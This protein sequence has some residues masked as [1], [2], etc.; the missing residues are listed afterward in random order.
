MGNKKQKHIPAPPTREQKFLMDLQVQLR[1]E[2]AR[3]KRW[4]ALIG[5]TKVQIGTLIAYT[6]ILEAIEAKSV[7]N[8]EGV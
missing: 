5:V 7:E 6:D 4:E 8:F 2:I 1:F 3:I